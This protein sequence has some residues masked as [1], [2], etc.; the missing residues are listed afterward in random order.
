MPTWVAEGVRIDATVTSLWVNLP[1]VHP[2]ASTR[3]CV[4]K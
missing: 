2:T 1:H 3:P 4:G